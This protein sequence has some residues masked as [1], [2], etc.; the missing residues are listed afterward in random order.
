MTN[1]TTDEDRRKKKVSLSNKKKKKKREGLCFSSQKLATK[2]DG[3]GK[4]AHFRCVRG[5]TKKKPRK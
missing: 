4:V 3:V 1:G 5:K 2:L